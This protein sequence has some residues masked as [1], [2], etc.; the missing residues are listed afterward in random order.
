MEANSSN[1]AL[2]NILKQD[3]DKQ[4]YILRGEMKYGPYDYPSVI[5]MMQENEVF[6]YNYLWSNHLDTWTMVSDLPE[7]S[8][9]RLTMLIQD[10]QFMQAAFNRRQ[11]PRAPV[12]LS[13]LAHN[14]KHLFDGKSLNLSMGGGLFLLNDPLLLP[15]DQLIILFRSKFEDHQFKVKAQVIRK[16]FTKQ[17]LNI[18]SGLHYAVRFLEVQLPGP[19][20][21]TQWTQGTP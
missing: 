19:S 15:H 9:D 20:L 5:R 18:K 14:D 7:F 1:T 8:K 17:R 3:G 11:I 16:N 4:W 13:I 2:R 6:E 10:S 21:L 12:Q